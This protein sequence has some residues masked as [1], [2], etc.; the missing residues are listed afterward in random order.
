VYVSEEL[1]KQQ[2]YTDP[3]DKEIDAL[4]FAEQTKDESRLACQM[5]IIKSME[6]ETIMFVDAE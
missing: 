5:K 3:E 4:D 1:M 6:G 2:D